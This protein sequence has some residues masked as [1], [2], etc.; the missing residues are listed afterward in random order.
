MKLN[1]HISANFLGHNRNTH[2]KYVFIY[3]SAHIHVNSK[4]DQLLTGNTSSC[5]SWS[6]SCS[7]ESGIADVWYRKVRSALD[8]QSSSCRAHC[9][10]SSAFTNNAKRI[11]ITNMNS[12]QKHVSRPNSSFYVHV[13][14][15]NTWTPQTFEKIRNT[16]AIQAN[17]L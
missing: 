16:A 14:A 9:W 8:S 3:R 5:V 2:D 6:S 1:K 15:I 12:R 17:P 10:N 13:C 7:S 4:E 11:I